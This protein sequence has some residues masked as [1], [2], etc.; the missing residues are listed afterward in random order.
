ME[1]K[2]YFTK[3]EL[4]ELKEAEQY[5]KTIITQQFKLY[6]PKRLNAK[7]A[8]IYEYRTKKKLHKNFSCNVCVYNIYKTVAQLYYASIE[9]YK[10]LPDET[11]ETNVTTVPKKETKVETTKKKKGRPKTKKQ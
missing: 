7:V 11:K 9:Y 3:E 6:S 4:E 10:N 2:V 1:D 8:E 5:F